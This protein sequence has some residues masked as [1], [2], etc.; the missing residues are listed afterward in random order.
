MKL[1]API[2]A[3][4]LFVGS[5]SY[6]KA[7]EGRQDERDSQREIVITGPPAI[8]VDGQARYHAAFPTP[9]RDAKIV[10]HFSDL[11]GFVETEMLD[12]MDEDVKEEGRKRVPLGRFAS[13][14]EIARTV[15]FLASDWASY[16][17]GSVLVV[18][19]GMTMAPS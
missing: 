5:P 15:V 19:G 7:T 12:N 10:W 1:T 17:T 9:P 2:L 4:L 16:M 18:D 13:A 6:A 8:L 3:L 14:T 11:P